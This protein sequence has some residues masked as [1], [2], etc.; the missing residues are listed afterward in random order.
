MWLR[1]HLH[2][3]LHLWLHLRL[4]LWWHSTIRVGLLL[5]LGPPAK[6]LHRLLLTELLRWHLLAKLLLLWH[7]LATDELL[8][9][10]K[11]LLRNHA[12][13]LLRWHAAGALLLSKH[14]CR[15]PLL[16]ICADRRAVRRAAAERLGPVSTS[17]AS[18]GCLHVVRHYRRGSYQHR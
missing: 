18:A 15:R 17:Y 4:H 9:L 7:L 6:L 1:L 13:K 11:L 10:A 2:L 14:R 16:W 12:P 8:R 5:H 3:H